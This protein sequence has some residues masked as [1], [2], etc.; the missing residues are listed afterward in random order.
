[1]SH[2]I[3]EVYPVYREKERR[4]N[5]SHTCDACKETIRS[6]D[7]YTNVGIVF[8]GEAETIKRCFR[9]QRIHEHLRGKGGGEFWPAERLD[10]GESYESEW[11]EECPEEIQALAFELPSDRRK[12]SIT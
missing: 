10:C 7:L 11:E 2:C 12:P 8:Q 5:K 6:G 4:A 1:M 9:C 3:D